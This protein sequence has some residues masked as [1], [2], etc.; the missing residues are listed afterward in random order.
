MESV[1]KSIDERAQHK[2]DYDRKMNER[3]MHGTESEKHDTSS[4]SG[5]DIHAE[6]ADIKLV[7][8]KEPMAEFASQVGVNNFLPKPVTPPYLPKVRE[9]VLAKPHHVIVPGPSRNSSKESYGS[10]DMVHNYYREEDKKTQDKNR[11]LKPREM[12]SARTHHT[13]NTCTPKPRS[14]NQ[15][16]RNWHA[17][18]SSGA[19][20]KA[21]QKSDHSRN[22]SSF[23]DSKHFVCSTCLKCVFNA[24]HD[25]YITKLLKEIFTGHRFSPNKSSVVHEK[26][27]TPRSCLKWIPTGRIFNIVSLR[28][29]PTGKIF[30]SSTTNV[31]CEPLNGSNKDITNP[32]ECDQTLNVSAVPDDVALRAVDLVDSPVSTS[33]DQDAPSTSISSTKDQ[34]PSQI[35]S[36]EEGINFEESFAPVARIEAIRIFVANAAH[37]NMTI[38]RMDVKTKFSNGELKEEVYVSQPKGFVDQETHRM[39]AVD[40]T[41]FTRKAGNDLLLAQI[42]VDDIIFASTNIAMCNE[43]ANQMTTKFKMSMM[44]PDLICVVYL[45]AWYQAKPTKKHLNAVKRIFRYLKR[46]INMGLWYS[47]DTGMSLTAYADADHARCQDTRRITS[48]SAQLIGDKLLTDYGFQF[49]MI[50]LYCDNKSAI[51][52]CCNNVQ[53]SKSKHIDV[54]YHFIKEQVD[55][56]VVELYFIFGLYTSRLL[57]VVY[58]KSFNLLK[59]GLLIYEEAKTTSYERLRGRPTAAT[60]NHMIL[61]YDVL[62]IQIK[63]HT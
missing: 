20:L 26:T 14:N 46:T 37:K 38:F 52:L 29:V 5:N 33:I 8:D 36:Q 57:D 18:K 24:N 3:Q 42:Y 1:K 21:V 62:I 10:N 43:F 16:S 41:L 30:T 53:H 40:P 27:N 61:S 11:N 28:W 59:K 50:P 51:A 13:A 6:D 39:C 44:G 34:E 19:T 12:P 23:W 49:N 22:P 55:N 35:I 45:C 32:Y 9:S 4:R 2:K 58:K 7:N 15:T 17:S 25:A 47:K 63:P 60:K 48:G 56:V 31:D 54:R